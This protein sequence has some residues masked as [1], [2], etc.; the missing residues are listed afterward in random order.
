MKQIDPALKRAILS[1]GGASTLAKLVG[2]TPQAL[3]QWRRVPA[4]RVLA[5]E[6][7]TRGLVTRHELRPD[8]Y[9]PPAKR[10]HI[11]ADAGEVQP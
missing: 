3:W 1:V 9:P 11:L 7:A 10:S 2:V 6:A 5:V 4:A 8:F